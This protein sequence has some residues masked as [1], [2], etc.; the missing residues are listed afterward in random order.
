MGPA[1]LLWKTGQNVWNKCLNLF[2]F[3]PLK[4]RKPTRCTFWLLQLSPWR[5]FL[6]YGT[7][8]RNPNLPVTG[9][10]HWGDEWEIRTWRGW[11]ACNLGRIPKRRELC[12]DRHPKISI[13]WH[14]TNLN[15]C[16]VKLHEA[17]QGTKAGS[18]EPNI[19]EF[20]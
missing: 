8:R 1:I 16:Q 18:H 20:T 10:S 15:L 11:G 17:E 9:R 19:L 13:I 2:L 5:Q 6:D 4:E 7:G 3:K 12:K 14:S